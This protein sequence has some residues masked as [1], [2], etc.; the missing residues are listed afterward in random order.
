M[1]Q[2]FSHH[3]P[4]SEATQPSPFSILIPIC[5][6]D[7]VAVDHPRRLKVVV[8]LIVPI[9]NR[10][11]TILLGIQ[12]ERIRKQIVL[13]FRATD[14][15]LVF[16]FDVLAVAV[17]TTM[18]VVCST[19]RVGKFEGPAADGSLLDRGSNRDRSEEQWDEK[20]SS[21]YLHR[22]DVGLIVLKG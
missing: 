22:G 20:G 6:V 19:L 5:S 12:F 7:L 1:C 17:L 15:I 8:T 3:T 11:L 9:A 10:P 2:L 18:H 13:V 16:K 4:K 14:W 21:G